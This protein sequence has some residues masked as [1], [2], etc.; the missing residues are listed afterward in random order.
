MNTSPDMQNEFIGA[1]SSV[2]TEGIQQ[3]I[4]NSCY[5]IKVKGTRDPTGAENIFIIICFTNYS[6]LICFQF[7][8]FYQ[9]TDSSDAK[10]T[11]DVI[12]AELTKAGLTSSKI[13]SQ[14]YDGASVMAGHCGGV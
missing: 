2:V 12:L 11:T 1:M 4:R 10:S 14:V 7:F 8:W 3:E 6:F 9:S 13:L 5:T